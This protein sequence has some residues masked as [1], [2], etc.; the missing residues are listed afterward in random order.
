MVGRLLS[1]WNEIFRAYVKLQVGIYSNIEKNDSLIS[2][3]LFC[4][5]GNMG[6]ISPKVHPT[7]P[8]SGPE[9]WSF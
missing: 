2:S 6:S 8:G 3:G 5:L 1:F 9:V 4:W 7:G